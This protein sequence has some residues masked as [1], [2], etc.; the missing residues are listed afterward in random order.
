MQYSYII[1]VQ[2]FC[3]LKMSITQFPNGF[4]RKKHFDV[5]SAIKVNRPGG[6]RHEIRPIRMRYLWSDFRA[7]EEPFSEVYM[8]KFSLYSKLV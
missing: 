3:P 7:W 6:V 8:V 4:R 1:L 2:G 5:I